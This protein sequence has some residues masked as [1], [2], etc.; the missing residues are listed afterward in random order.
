MDL[1]DPENNSALLLAVCG[2]HEDLAGRLIEM[3]AD[4]NI[5]NTDGYS[6]L[7]WAVCKRTE[8]SIVLAASGCIWHVSMR[9]RVAV[10]ARFV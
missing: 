10:Y 8:V 2:Q 7:V 9:C 5:I 4:V 6:A 1:T 3:N